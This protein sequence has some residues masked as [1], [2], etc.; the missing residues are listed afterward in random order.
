MNRLDDY[1]IVAAA[2]CWMVWIFVGLCMVIGIG[3]LLWVFWRRAMP[4]MALERE[5][6]KGREK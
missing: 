1:M 2:I 4:K 3:S 6:V 5:P